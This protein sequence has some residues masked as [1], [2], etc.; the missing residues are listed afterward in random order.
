[1]KRLP[2]ALTI[3]G[4]DSGGGAGIQ[5][6]LK[7]FAA[8]HVHGTSVIACL[9]AQNP[10]RVLAAYAVHR[11]FVND[12]LEAVFSELP[13]AAMKTGMLYSEDIV[14]SVLK[15]L[16]RLPSNKRPPLVVDPVMISTSGAALIEKGAL[17]I[18]KKLISSASI[19][20]PNLD[21]AI[22]LLGRKIHT[23][24]EARQAARALNAEYGCAVLVKGG[25]L[26]NISQAVDF[27]FDGKTELILSSPRVKGVKTHG[28]GCAYSAAITAGLAKGLRL[29]KAVLAAKEFVSAAIA[30]SVRIAKHQALGFNA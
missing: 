9:T 8:L 29:E 11:D 30:N 10:K 18:L 4:S 2:I 17:K 27:F 3:A 21:E 15:Y 22:A 19:I 25:H 13:P 7:T 26:P 5:A 28:T 6:D 12:Q 20:T 16:A 14:A 1:M 23:P 24:E